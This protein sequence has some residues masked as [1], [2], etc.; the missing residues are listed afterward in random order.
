MSH[1]DDDGRRPYSPGVR[2]V[3]PIVLLLA[4]LVVPS[5]ANALT[6]GQL[7]DLGAGPCPNIDSAF[8]C[9]TVRVPLD[10]F[11]PANP[12]QIDVVVGVHPA[13][14]AH[15]KGLLVTA[16]GGPGASGLSDADTFLKSWSPAIVANYD[17]VYFDQR[18][19]AARTALGQ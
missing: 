14:A 18:G 17:V 4:T 10:H 2:R 12:A 16:V 7:R 8:R 1:A 11:D 5:A 15:S 3:L 6:P 9:I 13:A 19:I